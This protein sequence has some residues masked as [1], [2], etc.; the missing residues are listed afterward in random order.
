MIDEK[1]SFEQAVG[2]VFEL[3]NTGTGSI[4]AGGNVLMGTTHEEK[5]LNAASYALLSVSDPGTYKP[6]QGNPFTGMR[7]IDQ[8]RSAIERA[9]MDT[10]GRSNAQIAELAMTT[11]DFPKILEDVVNKSLRS[12]YNY[13]P[14]TFKAFARQS[15]VQDFRDK[16]SL[17]LGGTTL[18][19]VLEHDEYKEGALSESSERYRV[20]KH[21]RIIS[22]TFETIV[23][24]DLDALTRVPQKMGAAAQN[25]E[26]QI[27]YGL[28]MSNPVMSDGNR[29]FSAAHG[30]LGSSTTLDPDGLSEAYQVMFVQKDD[31]GEVINL[32]PKF[33]VTGADLFVTARQLTSPNYQPTDQAGINVVGPMLAPI[34]EARVKNTFWMLA[35][36]PGMIDGLEY[37]YLSGYEGPTVETERGFV[38]DA[39]RYKIRHIFGAGVL[40]WRGFWANKEPQSI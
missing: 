1:L 33:L 38:V 31:V 32:V 28:L 30:N 9:G 10:R 13:R 12:G 17:M 39:I 27:V 29:L 4:Q 2:R 20:Y 5:T 21:G 16:I 11:S 6:E 25:L 37:A 23:N 36:D 14:P 35:A 8:A 40:D 3:K 15:S 19:K 7:L 24:D 22:V 34:G 18:E 26:S